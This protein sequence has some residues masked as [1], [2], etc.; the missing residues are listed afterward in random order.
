MVTKRFVPLILVAAPYEIASERNL[1]INC[2]NSYVSRGGNEITLIWEHC[3][4]YQ[5]GKDLAS[6]LPQTASG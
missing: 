6:Q 3:Q 5:Y 4:E 2:V 1:A